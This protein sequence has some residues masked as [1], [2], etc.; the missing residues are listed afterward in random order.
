MIAALLFP[1]EDQNNYKVY[2]IVKHIKIPEIEAGN[3]TRDFP[4]K[5]HQSP[6]LT[7]HL[8][9][10]ALH[11]PTWLCSGCSQHWPWTHSSERERGWWPVG[12]PTWDAQERCGGGGGAQREEISQEAL[13]RQKTSESSGQLCAAYDILFTHLM[14]R[15]L[16]LNKLPYLNVP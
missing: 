15:Q 6:A 7:V 1:P 14:G 11:R 10:P 16:G 2:E 8:L 13:G 12:G 4:T 3:K 5:R 9:S